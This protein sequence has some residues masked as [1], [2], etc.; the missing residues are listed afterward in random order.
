MQSCHDPQAREQF[1]SFPGE[2]G[3]PAGLAQATGT[4]AHYY[5]KFNSLKDSAYFGPQSSLQS[6]WSKWPFKGEQGM[7]QRSLLTHEKEGSYFQEWTAKQKG[8]LEMEFIWCT[9]S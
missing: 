5:H 4:P 8:L 9:D 3:L 1:Q 6:F 7:K 2:D